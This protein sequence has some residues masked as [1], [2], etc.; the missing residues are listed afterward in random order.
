MSRPELENKMAVLLGGRAAESLIFEEVSTGAADDL[1]KVTDIARSMVVRYG[2]D[3][4]LGNVGI[5]P[6]LLALPSVFRAIPNWNWVTSIAIFMPLVYI[7]AIFGHF[8]LM[9]FHRKAKLLELCIVRKKE[10]L[11]SG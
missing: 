7:L 10:E 6:G 5:V 1:A 3:D 11:A 8:L 4:E 9:R 2:M